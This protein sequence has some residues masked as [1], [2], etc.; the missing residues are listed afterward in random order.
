MSVTFKELVEEITRIVVGAQD[1]SMVT[2]QDNIHKLF[3]LVTEDGE[4][5]LVP[6]SSVFKLET[7]VKVPKAATR[8][9]HSISLKEIKLKL[10]TDINLEKGKDVSEMKVGLKR[11]LLTKSTHVEFETTYEKEELPEGIA[12]MVDNLNKMI[13][14]KL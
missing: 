6:L 13:S 9:L 5:K 2:A 1:V 14:Q 10:S 12:L 7:D 4:E 11:K 8:H 3:T